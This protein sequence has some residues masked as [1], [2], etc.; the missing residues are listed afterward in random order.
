MEV[1]RIVGYVPES[2]RLYEFLTATEY[3]DFVADVRGLGYEEKKERI[4]R[5]YV[6][7]RMRAAKLARQYP[8]VQSFLEEHQGVGHLRAIGYLEDAGLGERERK[9]ILECL[10]L[11]QWTADNVAAAVKI[12]K[13]GGEAAEVLLTSKKIAP[14]TGEAGSHQDGHR[15]DSSH[16]EQ[17]AIV[18]DSTSLPPEDAAHVIRRSG[19]VTDALKRVQRYT[20]MIGDST[21]SPDERTALT[22]LVEL[23]QLLLARS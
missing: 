9:F 15:P 14:P 2:P 13:E 4:D 3:L 12:L 21:P 20:K 17:A 23:I 22:E 10:I 11:A 16:K 18:A 5:G 1:R 7:N 19:Q 6:R 8:E